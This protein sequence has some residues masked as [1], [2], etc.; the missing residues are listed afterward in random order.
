[1]KYCYKC[2]SQMEDDDLFCGNCG[3]KQ[4]ENEKTETAPVKYENTDLQNVFKCLPNM[5]LKPVSAGEE[6]ISKNSKNSTIIMTIILCLFSGILGVWRVQQFVSSI[7]NLVTSFVSTINSLANIMGSRGSNVQNSDIIEYYSKI[8]QYLKVPYGA[9][10]VQNVAVLIVT[11]IIMFIILYLGISIVDK[12]KVNTLKIY[13]T[14]I[15]SVIPFFY[16]K[17]LAIIVSYASNYA[18]FVIELV[19]LIICIG[20][21]VLL[22]RNVF[23]IDNNKILFIAAASVLFVLI[24]G[25]LCVGQFI[26]SD[27]RNIMQSFMQSSNLN[28]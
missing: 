6:F 18:G 2:G 20:T 26:Q 15:I 3:A 16:F 14:V 22:V 27:I 7:Q 10:F 4:Y 17:I 19:G 25:S 11:I 12:N 28:L 23:S 8:R 5:L 21:F 24:L 9:I 1:M 13:N